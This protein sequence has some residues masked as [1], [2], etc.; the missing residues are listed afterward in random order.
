MFMAASRKQGMEIGAWDIDKENAHPTQEQTEQKEKE[1]DKHPEINQ[2][3]TDFLQVFP[4]PVGH[5]QFF[6]KEVLN[7]VEKLVGRCLIQVPIASAEV[8]RGM[9]ANPS[10][11]PSLLSAL[12][13]QFPVPLALEP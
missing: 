7:I 12:L 8:P 11:S 10:P 3:R 5:F 2:Y 6:R 9:P 4:T 13:L 1:S